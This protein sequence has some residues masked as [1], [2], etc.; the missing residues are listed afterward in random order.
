M[1]KN[2]LTL[3]IFAKGEN[4]PGNSRGKVIFYLKCGVKNE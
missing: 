3:I 2:P 1:M 4:K